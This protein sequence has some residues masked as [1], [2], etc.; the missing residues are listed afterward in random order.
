LSSTRKRDFDTA[1]SPE[2]LLVGLAPVRHHQSD[3]AGVGLIDSREEV[4]VPTR[5]APRPG[6]ARPA[7]GG[8]PADPDGVQV[9][10]QVTR[11]FDAGAPRYDLLVGLNP[12]YHAHLDTAAEAL[13]EGVPAPERLIDLGCGSGA[14]T[15]ALLRAFGE[16]VAILGVDASA[17]MLAQAQAKEWPD[18]VAFTPGRAGELDALL[19]AP[20]DGI[21]AA[22]LFR[23][24]PAGQRDQ[25]LAD[26]LAALRPGGTLV[27][28]E[29]SVA[30]DP[31]AQRVWRTVCRAVVRPLA[32]LTGANPAL[33][34][35]LERSVLEFDTVEAFCDRMQGVGFAGVESRTVT[36]WQCGILHI[37][38]ARRPR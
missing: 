13:A 6:P 7:H 33:Y 26:A 31:R 37:I 4:R 36:G 18:S 27:V 34:T 23:N 28:L 19:H 14:S 16:R 25:A 22:Y 2:D 30:G 1:D 9:S 35:Y 5:P 3:Q 32:R 10:T 20:V 38:R 11:E 24:V 8:V 15:R 12:G 17:G 21:L 29:Y